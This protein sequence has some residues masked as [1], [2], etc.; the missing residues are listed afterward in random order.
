MVNVM[1]ESNLVKR[2]IVIFGM[3]ATGISVARYLSDIGADFTFAD[4]RRAP[5]NLSKV[6]E[7]SLI[8]I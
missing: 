1:T 6:K 7:L 5:A 3:G 8:H 2:N 4:S